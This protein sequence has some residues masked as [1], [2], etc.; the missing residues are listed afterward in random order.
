MGLYRDMT[1]EELEAQYNLR[2]RRPDFDD[3]MA[4][5]LERCA[6]FREASGARCDIAY[7]PGEREQF[8]LFPARQPT[9][10][11]LIYIHGGYWQ[12]GDKTMYSFV[13]EP[14][15]ANGVAVAVLNYNLCP[16]VRI[17]E[18]APQI[19]R[20]VVSLHGSAG[21]FGYDRDRIYVMGHSAGG[22]LTAMMMATDWPALDKNLPVDLVKGGVP[23]S[24]LFELEPLVHTSINDGPQ[25][26]VDE[27]IRESPMFMEPAT[28][29]PQLVVVGG[30]ETEEF[31][32]QS[33]DYCEKY[34]TA[35]RRIDRYSVPDA[36]H[37]DELNRL[38][39]PDSEL[40]RR[41]IDLIR[42]G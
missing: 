30:A 18:I 31:H 21:E 40:F 38:A 16:L 32:R 14:F 33:D 1:A 42:H 28:D 20:A 2:A 17:G 23:I 3:M 36:D 13:A 26:D 9:G 25:M 27:A 24:A 19:Q 29:A 12:R 4:G 10:H 34:R 15:L 11:L 41:S 8:D 7:G 22:H 6:S 5:W 35:T 37:F 39:E